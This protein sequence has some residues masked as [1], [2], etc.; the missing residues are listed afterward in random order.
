MT[1]STPPTISPEVLLLLKSIRRLAL[2]LVKQ[3]DELIAKSG[4]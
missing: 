4:S 3:I 1:T 2:S